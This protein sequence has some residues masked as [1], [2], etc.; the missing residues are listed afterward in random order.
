MRVTQSEVYAT[1]VNFRTVVF[2][3]DFNAAS[4][5]KHWQALVH[6]QIFNFPLNLLTRF[7]QTAK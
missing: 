5:G 1:T 4:S 6:Q 2:D 3:I 7:N